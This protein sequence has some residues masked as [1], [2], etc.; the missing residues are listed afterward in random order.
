MIWIYK[1]LVIIFVL[2]DQFTDV[3][4]YKQFSNNVRQVDASSTSFL[5]N[6][7]WSCSDRAIYYSKLFTMQD[8]KRKETV[9]TNNFFV[10]SQSQHQE[11]VSEINEFFSQYDVK[12]VQKELLLISREMLTSD[13]IEQYG[14]EQVKD[15][16]ALI[17]TVMAF[18]TNLALLNNKVVYSGT[19]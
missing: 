9:L 14:I 19:N 12:H 1:I 15:T 7:S 8:Q 4:S 17:N 11:L 2:Q 16:Q 6:C 5:L 3:L 18:I 10:V 13:D